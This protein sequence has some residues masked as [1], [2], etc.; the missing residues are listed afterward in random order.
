MRRKIL[1][2]IF[3]KVLKLQPGEAIPEKWQVLYR[4]FFPIKYMIM[5]NEE[6]K[7][8]PLSETIT[9][10]GIKFSK[11]V[12]ITWSKSNM[13]IPN[14]EYFSF[15]VNKDK[16]ISLYRELPKDI[17]IKEVIEFVIKDKNIEDDVWNVYKKYLE[18]K[19]K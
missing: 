7:Y 9:I 3:S 11:P 4:I 17:L 8:D 13:C 19:E 16:T 5:N 18:S 14:N 2:F 12:F 10:Y 6:I 15:I 1:Y